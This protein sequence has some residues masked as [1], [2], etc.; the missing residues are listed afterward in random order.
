MPQATTPPAPPLDP[1][2]DRELQDADVSVREHGFNRMTAALYAK[3]LNTVG[4]WRPY[5]GLEERQEAIHDALLQLWR[6]IECG[7]HVWSP[8]IGRGAS[9]NLL[10]YIIRLRS[11]DQNRALSRRR[12]RYKSLHSRVDVDD[13]KLDER[14]QVEIEHDAQAA[15]SELHAGESVDSSKLDEIRVADDVDEERTRSVAE[16]FQQLRAVIAQLPHKAR[17]VADIAYEDPARQLTLQEIRQSYQKRYG[18][19]LSESAAKSLKQRADKAIT[20]S[21][22]KAAANLHAPEIHR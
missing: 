9:L 3:M 13:R 11:A 14:E 4:Q 18:E 22:T 1:S 6:L 20:A 19:D 15:A 12:A 16:R 10:F 21:L 2:I 7:D 5:I 17:R 8:G